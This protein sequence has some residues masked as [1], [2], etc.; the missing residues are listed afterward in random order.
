MAPR[1]KDGDAVVAVSA[2]QLNTDSYMGT[3]LT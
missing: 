3:L 1:Y 2:E